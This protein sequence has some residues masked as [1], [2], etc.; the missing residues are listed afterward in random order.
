MFVGICR[1]ELT[2]YETASL[3]EKRAVLQ[4][5][6]RRLRNLGTLSVAEVDY[7]DK[8]QRAALG[9][10]AVGVDRPGVERMLHQGIA[11]IENN[12]QVEILHIDEEMETFAYAH[13]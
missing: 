8:W 2:L 5:L 13:D 1:V 3:K 7:H 11:L 10:A 4:S 6:I 12:P 9:L